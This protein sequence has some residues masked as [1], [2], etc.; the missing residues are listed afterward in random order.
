MAVYREI[1]QQANR[2][3]IGL[4]DRV[5]GV[6]DYTQK[7]ENLAKNP[8]LGREDDQKDRSEDDI[9]KNK[10]GGGVKKTSKKRKRVA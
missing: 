4:Y 7:I 3:P 6:A 2:A 8:N 9:V 1:M 5:R 10:S